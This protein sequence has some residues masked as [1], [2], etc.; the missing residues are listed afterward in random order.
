MSTMYAI[1]ATVQ[2]VQRDRYGD[3]WTGTRQ[4]PTFFLDART[5][6]IVCEDHAERIARQII[7]PLGVIG[8]AR[9]YVTAVR[10]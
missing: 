3:V 1:T 6:G 8:D 2:T 5:Q 4:V 10:I 7:D 9:I